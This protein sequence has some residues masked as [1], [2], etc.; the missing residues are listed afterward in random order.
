K[1]AVAGKLQ[2]R[3]ALEKRGLPLADQGTAAAGH[4]KHRHADAGQRQ[5]QAPDDQPDHEPLAASRAGLGLLAARSLVQIVVIA[6]GAPGPIIVVSVILAAARGS[7]VVLFLITSSSWPIV[8]V[9]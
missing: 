7:V 6:A 4:E 9:L 1:L 2:A 8:F 5:H 3:L